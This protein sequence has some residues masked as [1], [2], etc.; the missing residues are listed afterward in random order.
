MEKYY[1]LN[2]DSRI[3]LERGYLLEGQTAEGRIR[4]IAEA[5]GKELNQKD[6]ADKFEDYM[7]RGW[8]SLSSPI[9]ANYGLERGLP[10]SCF[11]SYIDDTMESILTKQA[12]VGMMTK[13]GGGTSGYF[14]DLRPRGTEINSGG[15]SNGPVH[16]MELFETVTNVVSQSNVRRG[17]FAAYLPIDHGDILEF[18]QIR[19]DGHPIQNM[20]IGVTISNQWMSDMIDGDKELSLIHI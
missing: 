8:F 17:S 11:G 9:W 7:S 13:M 5:A 1:W 16:F 12:E 10:I 2:E 3:F 18:L 20:S 4:E 19:G 6:F 15:K 14:G